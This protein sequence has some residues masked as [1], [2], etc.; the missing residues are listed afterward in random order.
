M[1]TDY[2]K[3]L[4]ILRQ[5][6][7]N[8]PSQAKLAVLEERLRQNVEEEVLF[9]ANEQSRSERSRIIYSLN[10]I[11]F[12]LANVS[13]S[14]LCREETTVNLH[15][16]PSNSTTSMSA[17]HQF[18]DLLTSHFNLEELRSLCFYLAIDFEQLAGTN[19][20]GKAREL[21]LFAR[22]QGTSTELAAAVQALR[23]HLSHSLPKFKRG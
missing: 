2:E 16:A 7:Q 1:L 19:K 5:L 4:A 6:A 21:I 17:D 9:G 20:E 15:G 22:R 12:P 23:P 18:L 11:A 10:Q 3:G 14:Q 8:S 13:F